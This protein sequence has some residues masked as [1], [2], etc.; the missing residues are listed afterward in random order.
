MAEWRPPKVFMNTKEMTIINELSESVSNLYYQG[1]YEEMCDK[2]KELINLNPENSW[3]YTCW[4]IALDN[5]ANLKRNGDIFIDACGKYTKAIEIKPDDHDTWYN[6][7]NALAGLA[8]LKGDESLF[9]QARFK[10][11]QAIKI[12]PDDYDAYSGVAATLLYTA[13]FKAKTPKYQSLLKQAE[14]KALKAESLQKGSGA[15]N[16]ACVY[17]LK[18]DKDSCKKWL[19]IGQE[20]NTLQTREHAMKDIDFENM[21]NEP[22]FKKIKWKGEK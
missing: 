4:G 19:L 5:L 1:K 11:E 21:K 10:F 3:A 14:E 9:E 22:W 7:G 8:K 6:W 13:Q 12:N 2:C 18:N 20:T 16:L 15:Y 17:A